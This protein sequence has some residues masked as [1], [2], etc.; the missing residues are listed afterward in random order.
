MVVLHQLQH[1]GPLSKM[2]NMCVL[3]VGGGGYCDSAS[4]H[5]SETSQRQ[6]GYFLKIDEEATTNEKPLGIMNLI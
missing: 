1:S 5:R 6:V 3:N 2:E 4:H